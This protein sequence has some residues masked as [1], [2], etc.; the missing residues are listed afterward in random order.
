[1]T[2]DSGSTRSSTGA[3]NDPTEIQSKILTATVRSSAPTPR[4]SIS[5]S[6]DTT[7][8]AP[9]SSD[10]SPPAMRRRGLPANSRATA[11]ARGNAGTSQMR[12]VTLPSPMRYAAPRRPGGSRPERVCEGR[13]GPGRQ[14]APRAE[15][16]S[17]MS[18][19]E[20]VDVVHVGGY[21]ASEDGH[22][23]RQADDHLGRRDH[24]GEERQDLTIDFA[25]LAGEGDQRQVDRVQ[26]ELDR[27]ED[28]QR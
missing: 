14:Q 18:P 13:R 7:N 10:A 24:H 28:H 4:R 1:M 6:T 2:I 11:P 22:D 17:P 27:H 9:T 12:S 23:D 5:T 25:E 3:S 21:P 19:S 8:D 20:Q 15:P 26:L 16:R